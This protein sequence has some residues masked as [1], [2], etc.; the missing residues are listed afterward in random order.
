MATYDTTITFNSVNL[1]LTSITPIK[2][3]KTRKVVIGKSLTQVN[4]IGLGAQ[5]WELNVSGNVVGTTSANLST[6]RAAIE[7]LDSVTPYA[8]VDNIHNGTY[9]MIPGSL[10][11]SDTA[12]KVNSFYTY[13][14]KLVQE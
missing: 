13:T 7:A 6:N 10:S 11:F 4:I 5:Q 12:D 2:R 3:Q 9:I 8:Y 1:T 14:F